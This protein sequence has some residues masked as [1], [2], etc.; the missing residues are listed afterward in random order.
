MARNHASVV[1]NSFAVAAID[2]VVPHSPCARVPLRAHREHVGAAART[3]LGT[4]EWRLRFTSD[5]ERL[6]IPR[7][8]RDREIQGAAPGSRW[9]IID[10]GASASQPLP[11]G[12]PTIGDLID[13]YRQNR[14]RDR[15]ADP[16]RAQRTSSCPSARRRPRTL[17]E[18]IARARLPRDAQ[19]ADFVRG[20]LG[21]GANGHRPNARRAGIPSSG[22]R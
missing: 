20:A 4:R 18:T 15:G 11:V 3:G 12:V 2:D 21:Q 9:T 8:P 17:V 6:S 16:R 7:G 10:D 1:P 19:V 5:P 22:Y 14:R 13:F